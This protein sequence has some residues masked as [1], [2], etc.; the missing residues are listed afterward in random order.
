MKIRRATD[1]QRA[2]P[3]TNVAIRS[4]AVTQSSTLA[5]SEMRTRPR[6]GIAVRRVARQ[7]GARQ[8]GHVLLREQFARER[9]VVV[10]DGPQVEA[11]GRDRHVPL[12]S[13]PP[14]SVP[15]ARIFRGRAGGSRR[16]V[17]RPAR[18][19]CSRAACARARRS[20]G[21]SGRAG[22][23][24]GTSGRPRR[25][26]S[27]GPARSSASTGC[28]R[29]RSAR[30]NDCPRSTPPAAARAAARPRRNRARSSTRRRRSR[31]RM[32]SA[33]SS[34]RRRYASGMTAPVGLPGVHRNRTWQRLQV[35]ASTAS[36][37]GR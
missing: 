10:H 29:R 23:S 1:V 14:G 22:T 5:T 8:D 17:L 19:G 26:P 13:R 11:A 12:P 3:R 37:S 24:R 35:A 7:I 33:S 34:A 15:R 28:G 18:P 36:R 25:I 6:P 30:M 27:A 9:F 4:A 20:R 21:R 2:R 31:S 16:H 32:S